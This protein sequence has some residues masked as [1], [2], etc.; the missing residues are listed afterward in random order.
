MTDRDREV[1]RRRL[2]QLGALATMTGTAGCVVQIGGYRIDVAVDDN[3]VDIQA[4]DADAGGD[5][6]G[7]GTPTPTFGY[8]GT[9]TPTTAATPTKTSTQSA[10]GGQTATPTE[11]D[12]PSTAS[13]PSN[14]ENDYG[15][16]GYGE[17]GYGGVLI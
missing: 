6:S 14:P 5:S 4:D 16:Q 3:G 12:P 10:G 17:H 1:T 15:R 2:L 13:E 7:E 9:P 11:A 8:G